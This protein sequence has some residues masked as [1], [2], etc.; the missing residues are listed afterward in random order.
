MT[1]SRSGGLSPWTT[2]LYNCG[3]C[4]GHYKV[5]PNEAPIPTRDQRELTR[6]QDPTTD[7][8]RITNA[9]YKISFLH[10]L[11]SARAYFRPR[12]TDHVDD[13]KRQWL[14][15]FLSATNIHLFH[16]SSTLYPA[17]RRRGQRF[18]RRELYHNTAKHS[19]IILRCQSPI[20]PAFG[21]RYHTVRN[22]CSIYQP[23]GAPPSWHNARNL[24]PSHLPSCQSDHLRRRRL[25]QTRLWP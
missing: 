7:P 12:V 18:L 9:R 16:L 6:A 14:A 24:D 8:A 13:P 1:P 11:V 2:R 22:L 19:A 20:R 5:Q 15:C 10:S 21:L 4:A 23:G 25:P 3:L 17:P